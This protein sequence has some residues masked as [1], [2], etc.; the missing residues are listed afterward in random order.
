MNHISNVPN[1]KVVFVLLGAFQIFAQ[2]PPYELESMQAFYTSTNMA[3]NPC[4]S[5]FSFS[6][7]CSWTGVNC[8]AI[9]ATL[10]HVSEI[11]MSKLQLS[12]SLPRTWNLPEL[13]VLLIILFSQFKLQTVVTHFPIFVEV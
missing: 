3:T 13:I 9:N 8:I 5:N 10:I 2:L 6:D 1:M 11:Y 4:C 7:P 12:G